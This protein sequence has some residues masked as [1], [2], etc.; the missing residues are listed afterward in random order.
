MSDVYLGW[1]GDIEFAPNGDFRMTT[2]RELAEQRLIR[3]LLTNPAVRDASGTITR[4]GDDLMD[5][6][7]GKGL[8]QMVDALAT[9]ENRQLVD[10][11][12]R[13]AIAEEPDFIDQTAPVDIVFEDFPSQGTQVVTVHFQTLGGERG[14]VNVQL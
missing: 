11:R 5:Q 4:R 8:G 14:T 10:A 6:D 7:Y 12:I 13:S 2:Q 1:G 3:R 9:P